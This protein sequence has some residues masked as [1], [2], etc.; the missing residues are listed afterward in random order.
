VLLAVFAQPLLALIR[1]AAGS[2]LYSYILLV[3]VV[4]AYL[5]YIRRNQLPKNYGIELPLA[6]VFL[7]V[8]LG[9]M[10]FTYSSTGQAPAD[11]GHLVLLTLSF[12]CCLAA[13]GFFFFG[14]GWMGAA[15]FPLSGT[16]FL[17]AGPV[18]KLPNLTIEVA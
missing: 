12:L 10:A 5:L 4:S 13:G 14:R 11:N 8:G 6:I 9:V 15:A 16:P 18:F 17:W 3:P 1:Y 7:A 2:Q